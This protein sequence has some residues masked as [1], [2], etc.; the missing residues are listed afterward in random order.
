MEFSGPNAAVGVQ[1][2]E[3]RGR[4]LPLNATDRQTLDKPGWKRLRARVEL[5]QDTAGQK[6]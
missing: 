3:T 4:E 1:T 6:Q 5:M 2:N